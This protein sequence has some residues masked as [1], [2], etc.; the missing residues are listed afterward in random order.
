[1]AT[2]RTIEQWASLAATAVRLRDAAD[3]REIARRCHDATEQGRPTSIWHE[4]A[5]FYGHQC[6]CRPC[7]IARGEG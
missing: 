2:T 5:A 4:S 6:N 1:M 7:Q 3:A